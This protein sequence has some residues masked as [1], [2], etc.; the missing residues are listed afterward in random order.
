LAVFSGIIVEV[1]V[2]ESI[3]LGIIQG[4]TEFIPVSSSGHGVLAEY[5]FG[6]GHD[7]LF[8]E[9]INIGTVLALIIHFWP[10]I[11]DMLEEVIFRHNLKLARNIL[12]SALPAGIVGLA[13]AGAIEDAPFF[14]SAWVVTVMMLVVGVMM[15][16]LDKL[17]RLSGTKDGEH[18]APRRALGIGLAQVIALIPGTSR[19]AATIIGGRLSGLSAAASA[20]YSFL[21]SIPLMLGVIAKLMLKASDRDYLVHNLA[22]VI[23]GNI[24]AFISGLLAVGF[25][26][27]Y[28]SKHNLAVFGWYR[29]VVAVVVMG[30]LLLQ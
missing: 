16:R 27:R 18:L 23:V 13:F 10:K 3:T 29:V 15:I 14:A 12:I 21:V 9:F 6:M 22:P 26:M 4:I 8:L 20:E 2:L 17:P 5:F 25:L 7:H 19:S 11:M 30:V 28:L 24:F 1:S